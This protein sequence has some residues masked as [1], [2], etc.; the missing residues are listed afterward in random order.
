MKF[1]KKFAMI[2]TMMIGDMVLNPFLCQ[3]F[4]DK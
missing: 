4:S 3:N 1:M 2:K